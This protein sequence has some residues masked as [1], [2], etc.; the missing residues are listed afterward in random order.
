LLNNGAGI[1]TLASNNFGI[2]NAR[3]NGFGLAGEL[4]NDGVVDLVSGAAD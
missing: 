4:N 2:G 3:I 1:Y